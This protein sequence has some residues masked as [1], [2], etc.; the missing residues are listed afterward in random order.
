LRWWDD[1]LRWFKVVIRASVPDRRV[2][3]SVT[4]IEESSGGSQNASYV[5]CP[6][7]V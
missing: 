1:V 3:V 5:L 2:A 6:D 4:R 7:T